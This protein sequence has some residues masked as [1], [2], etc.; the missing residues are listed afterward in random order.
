V[1]GCNVEKP[2]G[3]IVQAG[4]LAQ[5]MGVESYRIERVGDR[6]LVHLTYEKRSDVAVLELRP[7][8]EGE[9]L[10]DLPVSAEV[11][12]RYPIV[13]VHFT[14]PGLD[15]DVATL[16]GR[17]RP[18]FTCPT[19]YETP[20]MDVIN[21][22]HAVLVDPV[23]APTLAELEVAVE[24]SGEVVME[25]VLGEEA[26]EGAFH[27]GA[28]HCDN[29]RVNSGPYTYRDNDCY[30]SGTTQYVYYWDSFGDCT[31]GLT[32]TRN[33]WGG[34][35]GNGINNPWGNS[36]CNDNDCHNSTG[37]ST[38]PD[39]YGGLGEVGGSGCAISNNYYYCNCGQCYGCGYDG[40]GN[41]CSGCSG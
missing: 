12:A 20:K 23:M 15:R 27:G 2:N 3:T 17:M 16:I 35:A 29:H 5:S 38:M 41:P 34:S 10:G 8:V 13:N 39:C 22:W 1:V 24:A 30:P 6:R 26:E 40:C 14:N 21:I 25:G 37:M 4:Q 9:M 33:C 18:G 7:M 19:E 36:C 28:G 32:V 11:L 31:A